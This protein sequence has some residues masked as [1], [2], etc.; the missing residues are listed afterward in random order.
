MAQR[1]KV[2]AAQV[3]RHEFDPSNLLQGE[4]EEPAL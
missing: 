4:G 2:L 3:P 1:L